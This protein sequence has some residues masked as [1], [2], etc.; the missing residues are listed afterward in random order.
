MNENVHDRID[1]FRKRMVSWRYNSLPILQEDEKV[2]VIL[3][4]IDKYGPVSDDSLW[5]QELDR[6]LLVSE[7]A[8][9]RYTERLRMGREIQEEKFRMSILGRIIYFIQRLSNYI[10]M[11]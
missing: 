1:K 2:L 3:N 4:R 10:A 5:M 11:K 7:D 6:A 9:T 8:V